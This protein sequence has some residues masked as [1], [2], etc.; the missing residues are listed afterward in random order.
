M[1]DSENENIL[2]PVVGDNETLQLFFDKMAILGLNQINQIKN[3]QN[4]NMDYLLTNIDEDFCVIESLIA[5][6]KHIRTTKKNTMT[7]ST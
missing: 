7:M 6:T 4:S 5:N 3:Q 1:C 2:L